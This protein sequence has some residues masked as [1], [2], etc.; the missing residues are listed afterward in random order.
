[1]LQ[2]RLISQLN[3]SQHSCISCPEC[4]QK[5]LV[6]VDVIRCVIH[7]IHRYENTG[8]WFWQYRR[9]KLL[10]EHRHRHPMDSNSSN[11]YTFLQHRSKPMFPLSQLYYWEE[12]TFQHAPAPTYAPR[13]K[14]IH[15]EWR[16]IGRD[17]GKLLAA[18][19]L[20]R[21]PQAKPK[22]PTRLRKIAS[23]DIQEEETG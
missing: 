13:Q 5:R 3:I 15:C 14:M 16:R 8:T 20:T 18:V 1:M 22:D 6:T 7:L 19:Q 23:Q 11:R 2:L 4:L 10:I 17:N 21:R 9:S 12:G